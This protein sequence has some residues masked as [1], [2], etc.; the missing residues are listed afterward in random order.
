MKRPGQAIIILLLTLLLSADAYAH[1]EVAIPSDDIVTKD[2]AKEIS[3]RVVFMHPFEGQYMNM[4]KP[5][6]FGVVVQGEKQ[7]LLNSLRQKKM[8]PLSFWEIAYRIRKP[9]DHVFFVEPEPY[10]EVSE[11]KF[12]VQYTKVIVN[13]LG[14][15]E[16]WDQEL[17][18]KAEIVPITRPYGLWTGNVFQ[19]QVKMD[20]RPVP[21]AKVEVEYYNPDGKVRVPSDPFIEQV[22]KTDPNGIFTYAIPKAGWWGFAAVMKGGQLMKY[23]KDGKDYPVEIGAVIWVNARNID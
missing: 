12:I 19:G 16:G 18:M 5:A 7:D 22:I 9:G 23:K 14:V 20:G 6:A 4:E 10:F 8:G 17:G 13:A 21:W 3:L 15:E 1:F 2:G 11:D